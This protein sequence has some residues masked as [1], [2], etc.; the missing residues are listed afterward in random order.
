MAIIGGII[1]LTV[2]GGINPGHGEQ[3]EEITRAGVDGVAFR[4]I[5]KRGQPFRLQATVDVLS[6]LSAQSLV[7]ACK[8]LQ[9]AL[10]DISDD[11]GAGWYDY[12]V[13]QVRHVQTKRVM[14]AV[15]GLTSGAGAYLVTVDFWLQ[16][17]A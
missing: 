12:V 7:N 9:G 1:F 17:T 15:G 6:N 2:K 10:V 11:T 13:L 8:S 5:G 14:R 4:K 16:A 3:V